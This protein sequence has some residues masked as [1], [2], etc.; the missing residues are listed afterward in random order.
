[1]LGPRVAAASAYNEARAFPTRVLGGDVDL[2][3]AA[4]IAHLERTAQLLWSARRETRTSVREWDDG[5]LL[6]AAAWVEL[7]LR[8]ERAA[9]GALL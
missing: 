9:S 7:R 6:H 8:D 4:R 2:L 5:Q 1:M 3:R